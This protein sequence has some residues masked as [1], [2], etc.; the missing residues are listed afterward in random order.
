M[1]KIVIILALIILTVPTFAR[2]LKPGIFSTQ[3][4]HF[5]RLYEFDKCVKAG[6]IPCRWAPDAGLGYGEPLFNF[7]TQL[8]YAIGEIFHLAGLSLIDTT[9][10]LFILSMV[11]SAL[12]MYLLANKVWG[13]KWAAIVS[14]L[15]YI[16]APYRAVD[17]WVRGA[18]PEAMSFIF[19]PL[20]I[21]FIELLFE[22]RN[23]RN[24]ILLGFV[25]AALLLT[26]NLSLLMFAPFIAVWVV[27]KL[28]ATKKY[29][30]LFGLVIAAAFALL[31]SA[32]YI[33]PVI[34]ESKYVDLA[35]TTTGYFDFRAHFV[36][37]GQLFISRFWGYGGSTWG[38]DDGLSLSIGQIQWILP[39]IAAVMLVLKK[40][41]KSKKEF[42][43]LFA[44]A[45]FYLFLT[46]N[47]STFIWEALDP[48]KY[49]QFP[50]RFLTISLF[51]LSLAS[52]V[53][54]T[55]IPKEKIRILFTVIAFVVLAA[56]NFSFFREDI[57]YNFTDKDLTTGPNFV[58]Q[59]RASIGDYWPLFGHQIPVDPSDGQ[60][61]NY[62]PG[63][64]VE[65]GGELAD[66]K[67]DKNGLIPAKGSVFTNTPVRTTGNMISLIALL[68]LV[69]AYPFSSR[70]KL[71]EK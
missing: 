13:N 60:Y 15:V 39:V 48:M 66:A 43:I 8:P 4:F 11:L 62:F 40:K 58:E 22:K 19:F 67:P 27:Y 14:S 68:L 3:D 28:I 61:I 46:H 71:Y 29:G 18:L 33:L 47:K 63:W 35:S 50:W 6:Q 51:C 42:L 20:I 16:Y 32:F 21:Y 10:L 30:T 17:V 65:Q 1:K 53:I 9:K 24:V 57:W 34:F 7:Y 70:F 44:M 23:M 37:I 69:I 52:G 59:T 45:I 49:I 38:T 55:L 2:M 31:L 64:K 56:A 25:V 36:T 26:H 54:V 41:L 5:F 12:S